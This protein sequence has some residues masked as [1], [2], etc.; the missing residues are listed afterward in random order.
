M[1]TVVCPA[2]PLK[3]GC[4]GSHSGY[5]CFCM[6]SLNKGNRENDN[7]IRKYLR[8]SMEKYKGEND[9]GERINL[10]SHALFPTSL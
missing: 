4:I 9:R 2:F 5:S 6:S 7:K 10:I 3:E 8:N 1:L